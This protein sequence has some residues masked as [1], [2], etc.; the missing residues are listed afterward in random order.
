MDAGATGSLYVGGVTAEIADWWGGG[1]RIPVAG[2]RVFARV[3]GPDGAPWLTLLH[4]FPTSSWDWAPVVERLRGERRILTLDFLGFGDSD[5]PPRHRYSLLEQADVVLA[6]WAWAG[7]ARTEVAAHDYA[8]SVAQELLARGAAQPAAV[9]FLNGGL[10]PEHHRPVTIQR[11]LAHR[12]AGP[13]LSLATSERTLT[14]GLRGV[15]ARP[16]SDAELHQH[17]LGV[18]RRGG[19]R[20]SHALLRY[21]AE[22]REHSGRWRR[23]LLEAPVP[24]RFVWGPLDPVSGAHMLAPLRALLPAAEVVELPGVGHYPQ[25]EAPDAVAAALRR[26]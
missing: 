11:L 5:K 18:A 1:Q 6:A 4:G 14:R 7:V 20:R 19:A 13:V 16:P 17:W 3:D 10:L 23:A 22:R 2:R 8:V 24:L 26:A 25:L 12:V 9:T 21:L 15:F